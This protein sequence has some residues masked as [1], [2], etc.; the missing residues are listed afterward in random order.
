MMLITD[1]SGLDHPP[2]GAPWPHP[3]TLGTRFRGAMVFTDESCLN[4]ETCTAWPGYGCSADFFFWKFNLIHENIYMY[5][6]YYIVV[7]YIVL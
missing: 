2:C 6:F 3:I 5:I 1:S 4:K 7:Y